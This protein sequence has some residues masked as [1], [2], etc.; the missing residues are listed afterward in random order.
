MDGSGHRRGGRGQTG[1][2]ETGYILGLSPS[3][4][5]SIWGQQLDPFVPTQTDPDS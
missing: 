2:P 3:R 1:T 4:P 5:R